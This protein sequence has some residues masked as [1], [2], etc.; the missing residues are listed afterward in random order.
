M[1]DMKK[2]EMLLGGLNCANCARKI[3]EKTQ[4][5]EE[6]GQANLNFIKRTLK[7]DIKEGYDKQEVIEKVIDIIDTTEPG[8]DIEVVN[9]KNRKS[10]NR[11]V[12]MEACGCAAGG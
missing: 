9:K 4:N 12:K 5:L 3:E 1:T 7:F 10:A 11:V 2:V 8:L 6:V